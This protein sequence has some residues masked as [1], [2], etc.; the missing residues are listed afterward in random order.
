M[1]WAKDGRE[2]GSRK[3]T[4]IHLIK[5]IIQQSPGTSIPG[6]FTTNKT[7]LCNKSFL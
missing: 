1:K 7:G 5:D 2:A 3:V 6:L 4:A